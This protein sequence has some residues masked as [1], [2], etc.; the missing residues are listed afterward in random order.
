MF[1]RRR[2]MGRRVCLNGDR[3]PPSC[4]DAN[5]IMAPPCQS[6]TSGTLSCRCGGMPRYADFG[7]S[8]PF[9]L[10]ACISSTRRRSPVILSRPRPSTEYS[11]HGGLPSHR[12]HLSGGV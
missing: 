12:F 2:R 9:C 8:Q 10:E 11:R 6:A 5:R 4:P 3:C 7:S 1:Q